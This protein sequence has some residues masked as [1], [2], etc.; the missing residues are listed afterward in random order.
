MENTQ[1]NVNE[2][3]KYGSD[4]EIRVKPIVSSISHFHLQKI[5]QQMENN[6]ISLL[7]SCKSDIKIKK[8][9]F[10][11]PTVIDDRNHSRD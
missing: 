3:R 10:N 1:Q 7:R 9:G 5:T 2:L 6:I 11:L 8:F 4:D